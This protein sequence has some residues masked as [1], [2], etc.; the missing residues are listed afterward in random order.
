[1]RSEEAAG[2]KWEHVNMEKGEL[3]IPDTKNRQP[4]HVPLSRQSL[5][6]LKQRQEHCTIGSPFVFPSLPRPQCLNKTGHVRL[7]AAELKAK[8][9]LD[10]TIHGL[11]RTFITTARRLKI[12]EDADR[13]TNHV[14][15]TVTGRHYD[16][17]NVDDLQKPL[18]TIVNE[19]ERLMIEG[20]G[21]KVIHLATAQ[22]E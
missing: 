16:G 3:Y 22:G 8:T 12:F 7:M 14:D 10:I 4:L 19:I 17:T 5:A 15:S 21:A 11:R 9:G 20:A 2:L 18:Q 1:M 6:I 13:L